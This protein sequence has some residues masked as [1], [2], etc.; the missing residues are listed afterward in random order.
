MNSRIVGKRTLENVKNLWEK[1]T[2]FSNWLASPEGLE[3]IANDLEI[4]IENPIREAKAA[5]FPCDIVGNLIGDEK[6]II[7]IENQ[8]GRTNH[9]HLAKIITYAATHKAMTGIWIAEEVADDHRQVI[10]WLNEN[11]S[12]S[13]SFFLAELKVYSINGS[14]PAPQL[15]IICR[16]NV[17]MKQDNSALPEGEKRRNEWR[18]KFWQEIH[19]EMKKDKLPFRL[20]SPGTDHWSSIAI[21]RSGF[22]L[23]MLLT[24]KNGTIAVEITVKPT[25]KASAFSQLLAQR[26]DIE[27]EI[28]AALDWREMPDKIS[29]RIVL[30][31]T[32]DPDNE[33][34]RKKVCDWFREWTPKL[35]NV[36]HQRIL[37]LNEAHE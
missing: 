28:G 20:Q 4:E 2:E 7:A 24:P 12:N 16:P 30:E 36:F 22:V 10:D 35:Y 5:N 1:E 31:V 17:T 6:H 14:P 13:I 18:L 15:D 26:Q 21:G 32:I 33:I 37:S 11:T 19:D 9:D 25:W 3:L 29:S 23:E 34:N 27:K 8:F